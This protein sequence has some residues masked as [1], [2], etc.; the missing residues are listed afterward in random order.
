MTPARFWFFWATVVLHI[1]LH[2]AL[3][4]AQDEERCKDKFSLGKEDFVL[5]VD[6]SVK[7]GATFL[8][9]PQ[10][11]RSEDCVL[12]C[13]N[14]PNC[15]LALIEHGGD[16]K[17]MCFVFNCLYK[18]KKVCRFVRKKGFSNY[19]LISVFKDY[20]EQK[21]SDVEDKHPTA[22]AG[23][24]RVVQ[25]KEDVIL[26]GIESKDDKKIVKYEWEMVSGDPSAVMTKGPFE[27]SVTVSNLSPGMYKFRLMVTDDADQTASAEVSVLVLTPEQSLHH[28]L[29][30]KKEGPCRGSFP[31]WHYNAAT[32]KCEKFKF[33]GCKP[34]RNNYLALNEC[35]NACDKV[36]AFA[37]PPSG[38]FGPVHD[39]REQCDAACGPDHFSCTNKCCIERELECDGE[40]QC[41]DGSDEAECS[42]LDSK[43]RRL[44]DIPVDKSR[45]HCVEPPVT[46]SCRAS[47][48][49]WYYNPYEGRCNRFNYGG[50][51]GNEN[52]FDTE[53]K[54]MSSCTGVSE[55]DV[56]A[57]RAQFQKQESKNETASIVIA[58]ILGL[59]IIILLVVI[60]C[61][62]LKGKKKRRNTHQV[63]A[64]NGGHVHAYEDSEKLVYNSTTK[65]V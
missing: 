3:S 59:A 53:E 22:V 20:L 39:H 5:D 7:D 49:N 30:P 63:V 46:G 10:V 15:N 6:E 60:A 62:L 17:S 9:S 19:V 1:C 14:D 32:E 18:Q 24:D 33:G 35:Q 8:G 25:P 64:I 42:R 61:C 41:S 40:P 56:F 26:N 50:C 23:Q 44:L 31:R 45:V 2:V 36:S 48:T 43:F 11:S 38:R 34:N 21:N 37:K 57:R 47:F 58:I 13:C 65:P 27:D 16:T 52:R 4:E 55:T 54:C 28:C 12:A 29:V 51:D